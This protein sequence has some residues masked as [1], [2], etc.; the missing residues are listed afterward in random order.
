MTFGASHANMKSGSCDHN[1]GWC[2][3]AFLLLEAGAKL[4]QDNQWYS[5]DDNPDAVSHATDSRHKSS[6][7]NH[8]TV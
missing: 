8:K 2:E 6:T 5:S 1:S 7:D 4:P 3:A